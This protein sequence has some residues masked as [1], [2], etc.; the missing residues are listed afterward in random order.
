MDHFSFVDGEA[1]I[2][3]RGHARCVA[4]RAVDVVDPPA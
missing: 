3:G 4:D 1:M 2:I